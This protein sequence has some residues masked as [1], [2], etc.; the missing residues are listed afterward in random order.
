MKALNVILL[1]FGFIFAVLTWLGMM[2]TS[3]FVIGLL[4]FNVGLSALG[5][6]LKQT[7]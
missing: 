6:L 2:Q 7:K 1:I 5:Y 4:W 3:N